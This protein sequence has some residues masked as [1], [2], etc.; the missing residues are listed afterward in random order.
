LLFWNPLLQALSEANL[1]ELR[2][3]GVMKG[4]ASFVLC[5]L[6]IMPAM[7]QEKPTPALPSNDQIKLLVAQSRRAFDAYKDAISLEGTLV[8]K[9][10]ADKDREVLPP[11]ATL[12]DNIQKNPELF[13][14]P[15]GF[16]LVTM[17][18]DASRNMAVCSGQAGMM[19]ISAEQEGRTAEALT[20][21]Q[22]ATICLDA[23]T[24]LY[25]VSET[26]VD[27][28]QNALLSLYAL[29]QQSTAL[30]EKCT[31]LLQQKKQ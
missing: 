6:A 10:S 4:L 27:M 26:A 18:D 24:L 1:R 12:L 20:K 17:L 29:Q 9:E 30:L 8:N 16:F 13:N 11:A 21:I 15:M 2:W 23:S 19:T 31:G 3:G 25:T 7:A 5:F 14:G 28:Y 22:G